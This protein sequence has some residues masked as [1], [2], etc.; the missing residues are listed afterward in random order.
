M[1]P[2]APHWQASAMSESAVAADVHHP[3]DVH[4]DLLSQI[5]FNIPLLVNH[6]SDAVDLFLRQLANPSISAY[7]RLAQYLVRARSPNPIYVG[8]TDLN[9]LIRWQINPCYS[10]HSS[11]STP[12]PA[13]P[14]SA[15]ALD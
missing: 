13:I 15:C 14:A 2:L 5:A 4:L 10:S 1:C 7:V 6:R 11:S 9:P 3:L 12:R 8:E